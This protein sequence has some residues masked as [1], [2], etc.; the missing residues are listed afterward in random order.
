[1][2]NNFVDVIGI[3]RGKEPEV[4]ATFG[5][6]KDANWHVKNTFLDEDKCLVKSTSKKGTK[7]IKEDVA[8]DRDSYIKSVAEMAITD[9]ETL[10][11]TTEESTLLKFML[12]GVV[13]KKTDLNKI[14]EQETGK[15]GLERVQVI[16]SENTAFPHSKVKK[17]LEDTLIAN[18]VGGS[19]TT[20]EEETED[21]DEEESYDTDD[22]EE[23]EDVEDIEE[24]NDD[25]EEETD[26]S[27]E[28]TEDTEEE[29]DGSEEDIEE[30]EETEDTDEETE[31]EEEVEEDE[32]EDEEEDEEEDEDFELD[33]TDDDLDELDEIEEE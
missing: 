7:F 13:D 15:E 5:D 3:T 6:R 22:V 27:E 25:S 2:A 11:I 1:M 16:H 31:D 19:D 28:E 23:N 29:N 14:L 33:L 18:L 9:L 12:D 20:E 17:K 26:D 32:T 10:T 24:E 30:E 4:L 8:T 21:S